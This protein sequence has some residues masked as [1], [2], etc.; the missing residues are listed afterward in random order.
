M[1]ANVR[2]RTR[3]QLAGPY[4][5]DEIFEVHMSQRNVK[6]CTSEIESNILWDTGSTVDLISA[7]NINNEY[8]YNGEIVCVRPP[9]GNDI[10]CLLTVEIKS[11]L[12]Y[13]GVI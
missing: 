8:Y 2:V 13:I 10:R 12:K 4:G 1:E 7:N 9:L 6:K 11:D 5:L 3:N